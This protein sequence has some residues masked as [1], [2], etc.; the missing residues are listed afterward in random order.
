[1]K[2]TLKHA[3]GLLVL[4]TF[5]SLIGCKSDEPAPKPP[6]ASGPIVPITTADLNAAKL[7]NAAVPQAVQTAFKHD[8]PEAAISNIELQ[9]TSAGQSFY[10][11]SFIQKGV[12]GVGRY[13]RH[14]R[15][16]AR[17]LTLDRRQHDGRLEADLPAGRN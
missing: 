2:S 3:F 8:Y 13:F 5:A 7:Q 15:A 1:M 9:M 14:R 6:M 17:E 10:T 16:I 12:G 11:I 4:L